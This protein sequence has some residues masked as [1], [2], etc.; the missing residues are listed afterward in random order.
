MNLTYRYLVQFRFIALLVIWTSLCMITVSF[1]PVLPL[2]WQSIW[3]YMGAF[4]LVSAIGFLTRHHHDLMTGLSNREQFVENLNWA[5][6]RLRRDSNRSFALFLLDIDRFKV[7]N[8]S[9]GH[10]AGNELLGLVG[11]RTDKALRSG[12]ADDALITLAR[13]GQDEF[14]A[15]I[16][17]NGRVQAECL[18]QE[19]QQTLSFPFN[20]GNQEVFLS[21][22]IGVVLS[23]PAYKDAEE[24]LH[25]ANAAM[26]RA[27]L[28][29]GRCHV[30]FDESLGRLALK[31]MSIETDLHH[32][33]K[34]QEFTLHYQ[35]II[36]LLNGQLRGFE[37]L[38]RWQHPERGLIS[39]AEFIP[40]AEE[41]GLIDSI[42]LWSL[43]EACR[44]MAQWRIQFGNGFNFG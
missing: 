2:K 20:I 11:K 21:M 3:G 28:N 44:Q 23:A 39:A 12:S 7:V 37:A 24:M 31:R 26:V 34:R 17:V 41:V 22:S 10:A 1:G 43:T 5:I 13:G 4:G 25:D 27:Q 30:M 16:R 29:G 42:G 40:V 15:L 38:I 36:S 18:A 19:I 6:S 8:G 33:L 9:L 35:P 32:A 14:A